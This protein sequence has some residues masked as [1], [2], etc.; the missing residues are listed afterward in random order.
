MVLAHPAEGRPLTEGDGMT[1]PWKELA[2]MPPPHLVSLIKQSIEVARKWREDETAEA[3]EVVLA[4]LKGS[5]NLTTAESEIADAW[6]EA[7]EQ[8]PSIESQKEFCEFLERRGTPYREGTVSKALAR[9][10]WELQ[11]KRGPKPGN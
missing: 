5:W 10:G 1:D 7:H 6:V 8:V 9:L 4:N 3:L 11:G 2:S